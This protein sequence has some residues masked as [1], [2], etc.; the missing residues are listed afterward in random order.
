MAKM[1]KRKKTADQAEL[2]DVAGEFNQEALKRIGERSAIDTRVIADLEQYHGIYDEATWSDILETKRSQLFFNITRK[3]TKALAARLGD[4]LFPTDDKNWGIQPSPVPELTENAKQAMD[5]AKFMREQAERQPEAPEALSPEQL[6]QM[7]PE[8]QQQYMQQV[9]QGARRQEMQAEAN[10]IAE[11]ADEMMAQLQEGKRRC[12]L[13][14]R[15]M[16]DQ[17]K[18]SQFNK[19]GRRVIF[20]ACKMGTGIMK[21]PV[22]GERVRRG[23]AKKKG[24]K[25][26]LVMGEVP[27]ARN[28][29]FWGFYPDMSVS[30]IAHCSD[31]CELHLSGETHLQEFAKRPNVDEE[32]VNRLLMNG[33][34][35]ELPDHANRLR[36]IR[37]E[38][39]QMTLGQYHLWCRSGNISRD[40]AKKIAEAK[41]DEDMWEIVN[42][43]DD[44][45]TQYKAI[46]W[47][48]QGEILKI[49]PYPFDDLSTPI[50][51]V[52]ALEPDEHSI[53]G[54]G[55]PALIRDPQRALNSAVRAMMD[56]A[57]LAA[58]PQILVNTTA[59]EPMDGFPQITPLK[60]WDWKGMHNSNRLPFETFDIPMRQQ[61]LGA[62]I[63]IS[64]SFMDE[65]SGIPPVATGD[66]GQVAETAHGQSMLMNS[67]NVA[68]RDMVRL[69]DE[70]II[71][72]V[73]TRWYDWNMKHHPREEIK[74]DYEVDAR[75]S[76]VLLVK[77]QQ[78]Q[79]LMFVATQLGGHP[80][81]ADMFKDRDL[82]KKLFQSMM[83]PADDI[84]LSQD[85]I[86][87]IVAQAQANQVEQQMAQAQIE[88]EAKKVEIAAAQL[89]LDREK[90]Q[91]DWAK[92]QLSAETQIKVAGL[93]YQRNLEAETLRS[94]VKADVE[95][96]RSMDRQKDRDSAERKMAVELAEARR[97]PDKP[98]GGSV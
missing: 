31:V 60:R 17:L 69:Y 65:M 45:L 24:K 50:Y 14:E 51:S 58:G 20:D 40:L 2:E 70:Q 8:Q 85:E 39:Q 77:E 57:S 6:Q 48:C 55:V 75:G 56:N 15:V 94:N 41:R 90:M 47:H 3:Q 88:M 23:W 64:R 10:Q 82:L 33:P 37:S 29:S 89:E 91:L 46:V 30:D 79:S 7:P 81:Y 53:F 1:A 92:A 13:M 11:F 27:A 78:Q 72:P 26:E 16:F 4:L 43:E 66:Q 95:S 35:H 12:E 84:L 42:D 61:E 19:I 32:A 9:Q 59:V 62:I 44:H 93:Q 97:N 71:V 36:S 21:G 25:P 49:E 74:G 96:I 54:Y 67:A 52:Y 38:S 76:S 22:T 98:T 63:S 34:A 28:V 87:A 18:Q 86:D 5:E 68:F 80:K 83:I 73:I